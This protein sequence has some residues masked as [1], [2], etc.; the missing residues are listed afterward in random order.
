M[1]KRPLIRRGDMVRLKKNVSLEGIPRHEMFK[2][3]GMTLEQDVKRKL[4][5]RRIASN[6]GAV[7]VHVA[8]KTNARYFIHRRNLWRIP[9]EHQPLYKYLHKNNSH[10][11]IT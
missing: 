7:L 9:T 2:V 8:T 5:L 4:R 1:T 11:Q 10:I 6:D 3:I